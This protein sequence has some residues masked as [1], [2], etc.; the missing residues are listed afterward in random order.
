MPPSEVIL[1]F[2]HEFYTAIAAGIESFTRL[3][4]V[5]T[6]DQSHGHLKSSTEAVGLV[7]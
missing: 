7:V 2:K 5:D 3:W 6:I 1:R 4:T